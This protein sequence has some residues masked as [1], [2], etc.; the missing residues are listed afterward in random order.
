MNTSSMPLFAINSIR[1]SISQVNAMKM[2]K[3]HIPLTKIILLIK[4]KKCVKQIC[5]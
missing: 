4:M 2:I 3:W 5:H 1:A